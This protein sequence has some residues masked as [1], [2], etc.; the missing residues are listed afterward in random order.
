MR[1][2]LA[3][4]ISQKSNLPA[5]IDRGAAAYPQV[6]LKTRFFICRSYRQMSFPIVAS[7]QHASVGDGCEASAL[8]L[9]HLRK[10]QIWREQRSAN[11]TG[12]PGGE[13]PRVIT[14]SRTYEI[15]VI[16]AVTGRIPIESVCCASRARLAALSGAAG[17]LQQF[18]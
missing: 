3:Y 15:V 18:I 1:R 13:Y 11:E 12:R 4:S 9:T 5:A 8:K 2:T 17:A 16:T 6:F 14:V 10:D 7:K